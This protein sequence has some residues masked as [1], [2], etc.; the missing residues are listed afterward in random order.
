M[1][2]GHVK[3]VVVALIDTKQLDKHPLVLFIPTYRKWGKFRW[4]KLS[5]FSR[6]FRGPQK[7]CH[8]YSA[9]SIKNKCQWPC[10]VKV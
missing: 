10:T 6:F 8:E 3:Y 1:Y 9:L 2:S 4:A 5:R 7:F